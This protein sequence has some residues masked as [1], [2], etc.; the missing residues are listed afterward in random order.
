[1]RNSTLR[2]AALAFFL[3]AL[4]STPGRADD[5]LPKGTAIQLPG[6]QPIVLLADSAFLLSRSEVV[7][8]AAMADDFAR[9]NA[10]LLACQHRHEVSPTTSF[11]ASPRGQ[12]I[13][14]GGF[15]VSVSAAFA[16]GLYVESKV[17]K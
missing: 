11:W 1:M 12:G 16:G 15:A 14:V 5:R 13:V 9:C 7:A 8:V 2:F 3:E 6:G 10:E 4:C 17:R